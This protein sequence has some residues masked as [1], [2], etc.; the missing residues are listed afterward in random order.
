M[1]TET[2][3]GDQG[4]VN[5]HAPFVNGWGNFFAGGFA[6]DAPNPCEFP[7]WGGLYGGTYQTYRWMLSH[8]TNR[9]ART[10][11]TEILKTNGWSIEPA[12]EDLP[13]E[14]VKWQKFLADAILPQRRDL[15][16][17]GLNGPDMGAGFAEIIWS[18]RDGHYFPRAKWLLNDITRTVVD[19]SGDLAGLSQDTVRDGRAGYDVNGR[20]IPGL[21]PYKYLAIVHDYS[22]DVG[23]YGRSRLENVR[24]YAWRPWL[25]TMQDLK[26]LRGK[27]SGIIGMLF[28][29][30]GSFKDA[31]TG[32]TV[33]YSDMAKEAVQALRRGQFGYFPTFA[34][35]TASPNGQIDP[36]KVEKLAKASLVNIEFYDAGNHAPAIAGFLS[37][38]NHYESMMFQGWGLSP[39]TGLEGQHGTKAEAGVH[40]ETAN[41]ASEALE[42]DIAHQL[43]AGYVDLALVLNFGEKARGAFR[44][45]P[46]PLADTKAARNIEFVM[47]LCRSNPDIGWNIWAYI[48]QGGKIKGLD[49]PMFEGDAAALTQKPTATADSQSQ[50]QG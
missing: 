4:G 38:L 18:V 42:D 20:E 46:A 23:Y 19:K 17:I 15:L 22:P 1:L 44:V 9:L 26:R 5:G 31:V 7:G 35:S 3:T 30:A 21:G 27:L 48:A 37:L 36:E 6:A 24:D 47:N 39:R 12:R 28:A 25:D 32:Q 49:M 50:P 8:P 14:S 33:R 41:E 2:K 29:P 10:V 43:S 40:T 16:R 11:L 13:T 34:L 45:K